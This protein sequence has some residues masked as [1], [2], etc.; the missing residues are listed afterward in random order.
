MRAEI[1][2]NLKREVKKR[3]QAKITGP[4]DGCAARGQSD[5]GAGS[6]D[7]PRDRALM[8]DLARQDMEQRGM[9]VK[10]LPMQPEWFVD[11]ARRRVGW[12]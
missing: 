3:L 11:Q 7:P 2:D 4:G 10:D 9:K 6:T 8:Q 1:E 12:A 5:R